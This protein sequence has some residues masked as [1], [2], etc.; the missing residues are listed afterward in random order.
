MHPSV[1]RLTVV[2]PRR[3][4]DLVLPSTLAVAELMPDLV[5]LGGGP[6]DTAQ[7]RSWSLT[8]PAGADV[9]PSETL[10]EA[11]V[12]DGDVLVLRHEH[13][14]RLGMVG[15]GAADAV[16]QAV[17]HAAGVWTP[18]PRRAVLLIVAGLATAGLATA[19]QAADAGLTAGLGAAAAL[20]LVAVGRLA[21][22][23]P[24]VAR[25]LVG[26]A[27]M[28]AATAGAGAG[29]LAGTTTVAGTLTW[30]AGGVL[31]AAVG[32]LLAGPAVRPIAVA[33]ALGAIVGMLTAGTADTAPYVRV[34]AVAAVL[35]V[36]SLPVLPELAVRLTRA[37][38]ISAVELAEDD[39]AAVTAAARIQL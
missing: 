6:T 17:D 16:R 34:A 8:R 20:V 35:V 22:A 26:L 36:V 21:S 37:S 18:G 23:D 30:A 12:R 29:A 11:G 7:L 1:S 5:R 38:L 3:R 10:H 4:L 33:A 39:A 24:G 15:Y 9:V 32:A 25:A 27:T 2:G 13:A 14:P 28:P 31:A 19:L